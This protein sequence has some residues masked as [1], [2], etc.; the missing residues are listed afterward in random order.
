[1]EFPGCTPGLNVVL[2][3]WAADYLIGVKLLVWAFVQCGAFAF[4]GVVV[5]NATGDAV[6]IAFAAA[7]FPV[8]PLRSLLVL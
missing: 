1:M 4:V 5:Y 3:F 7:N 6:L 2:F 8:G